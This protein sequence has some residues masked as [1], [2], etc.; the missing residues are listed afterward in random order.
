MPKLS[1][2]WLKKQANVL[3][4]NFL[5]FHPIWADISMF[6]AHTFRIYILDLDLVSAD[7][8]LTKA[9]VLGP[10]YKKGAPLKQVKSDYPPVCANSPANDR[11]F[12]NGTI[13][14]VAPSQPCGKPTRALL[15]IWHADCN[16]VY[17]NT[18][19]NSPDYV[20]SKQ[21]WGAKMASF[22]RVLAT[23]D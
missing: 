16:G 21:F 13:R 2:S 4:S 3:I 7:C 17:S 23:A 8:K 1:R 20:S 19:P 9:D 6:G 11:L 5:P 14:L 15:D 10:Y 12:L 18:S 22:I